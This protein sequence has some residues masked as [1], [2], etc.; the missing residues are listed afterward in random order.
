VPVAK[1]YFVNRDDQDINL[2]F[3]ENFARNN[4][5]REL[6]IIKESQKLKNKYENDLHESTDEDKKI[7]EFEDD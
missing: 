2:Q 1:H 4:E 6:A 7:L 5:G 3:L